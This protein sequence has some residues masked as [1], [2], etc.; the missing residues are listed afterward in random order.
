MFN[1]LNKEVYRQS[2]V[3]QKVI[4]PIANLAKGIYIVEVS[5][6]GFKEYAKFVKE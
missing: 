3:Q 4:V 2:F 1:V 5:Y 6:N